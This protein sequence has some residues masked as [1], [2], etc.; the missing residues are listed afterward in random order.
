MTIAGFLITALI[1]FA[2]F[3]VWYYVVQRNKAGKGQ[4]AKGAMA[5]FMTEIGVIE[6]ASPKKVSSSSRSRKATTG[7]PPVPSSTWVRT[8][9]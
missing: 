3:A 4:G 5:N 7:T 2:V 1:V 8:K 9:R 6:D